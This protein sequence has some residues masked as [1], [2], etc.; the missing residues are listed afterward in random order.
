ML[1]FLANAVDFPPG[2]N[3]LGGAGWVKKVNEDGTFDVKVK[4]ID[5]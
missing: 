1:L 2:N 4:I 5:S 3:K